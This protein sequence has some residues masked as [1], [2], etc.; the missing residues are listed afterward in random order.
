MTTTQMLRVLFASLLGLAG[1]ACGGE[2]AAESA[3]PSQSESAAVEIVDS[4]FSPAQV[5]VVAQGEVTW[6]NNDDD[7][8]TVTFDDDAIDSSGQ[9]DEGDT[10][11]TAFDK[12]GS[13]SYLCAV[14]PE[15]QGTVSVQ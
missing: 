4:T 3:P 6:T 12:T 13:F 11:T 9:L 15:M 14:H 1:V 10:F 2:P 7:V 5:Q 8:H